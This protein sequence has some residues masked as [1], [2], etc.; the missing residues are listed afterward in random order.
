MLG[1]SNPVIRRIRALRRDPAL[2]RSEAVFVAE[3]IHLAQEA[4]RCGVGVERFLVSP[5]LARKAEGRRLL[6]ELERRA[7]VVHETSDSVLESLQDARSPQP[8]LAVVRR[9][10]RRLDEALDAAG[11]RPLIV[12]LDGIQDPGNLGTV[13][14]SADAAGAQVALV[15]GDSVDPYH[16]R[17][18]RA[19]MGSIFR[20]PPSF[21]ALR[22]LPATLRSRDVRCVGTHPRQGLAYHAVDLR[23]AVALFLGREARGL[24]DAL[25]RAMDSLA[26]IPM[27]DGVESLSVGAAAAVLLFE[28]AHQRCTPGPPVSPTDG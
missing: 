19:S 12:V 23:G 7:V 18:V 27:R 6:D 26:T 13:L 22:S 4:L 17:C 15:T 16:P 10:I 8:I 14:R 20:L 21:A 11:D 28:A 1:K 2:R 5:A 24:P 3:G 9:E 25:A